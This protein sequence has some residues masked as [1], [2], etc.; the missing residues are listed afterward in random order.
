MSEKNEEKPK[1]KGGKKNI[2][3]YILNP[4][5]QLLFEEHLKRC[6]SKTSGISY[7]SLRNTYAPRNKHS[8]F[9]D[10]PKEFMPRKEE[11]Y[12]LINID[13]HQVANSVTASQSIF[14]LI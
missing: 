5:S 1:K 4:S 10:F 8:A 7:K 11:T 9:G 3:H 2:I 14:I 6:L 12:D 13:S